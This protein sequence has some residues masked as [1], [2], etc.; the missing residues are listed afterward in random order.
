MPRIDDYLRKLD[1]V[2]A[3]DLL[4]SSDRPPLYRAQNELLPLPGEGILDDAMLRAGLRELLSADEWAALLADQQL[5]FTIDLDRMRVRGLCSIARHGITARFSRVREPVAALDELQLP[6]A[7]AN[8]VAADSGLVIVTG[9]AGSGKTTLVAALCELIGQERAVH[10]TSL[11][12]TVE[13]RQASR[14]A[15]VSQRAIGRHCASF[16]T[17]V[18]TALDTNADVIA[19]AS[20]QTDGVFERL[21]EAAS[22]GV[23]VLGEVPGQGAVNALEYLLLAARESQRTQLSLDLAECLLGIVSLDLLPKKGG[24]RV[25]AAEILLCTPNVA[26]LLRDGKTSMLPSL[27]DREPGMQSMDRSLLELA[28]R[29]LIEGR[30]AYARAIDKRAFAAWG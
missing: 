14:A 20:L 6:A 13:Y 8:L 24:G 22:A 16:E 5:A 19:C 25:P 12:N 7:L 30:E 27:L 17:A 3:N 28:T 4:L 2:A 10:L 1:S 21:V 29:G 23:L 11:G 26:A 15:A 18:E 9:A